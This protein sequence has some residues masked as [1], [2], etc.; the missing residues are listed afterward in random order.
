MLGGTMRILMAAFF[1]ATC[2][3]LGNPVWVN[4]G[5][6]GAT[7]TGR[8]TL[9]GTPPKP[10]PVD[11]AKEPECVKMHAK[12]PL[13]PENVVTGRDNA[14]QNVVVYISAGLSESN[15][16]TLRPASFDQQDC[17]YTTHVLAVRT[18]QEIKIFNSD[19]FSHNIHPLA[20]IN[21]EWNRIQPPNVPAFS[22]SYEQEE[23]IHVKCNI[24]SWMEG[25]FAVVKTSHFDVTGEDGSFHLPELPPGKYT[26]TAWQEVYGTQSQEITITG[27]ETQTVNFAFQAK[28]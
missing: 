9:K 4:A 15:P 19:P 6:S 22:Y 28:P 26:I 1:L 11:L 12:S 7:I 16:S 20:K 21:R 2:L 14:L 3:A 17:H 27:S 8:V 5:P 23:F 25:Y 10:K 18:G 24:H 13:F